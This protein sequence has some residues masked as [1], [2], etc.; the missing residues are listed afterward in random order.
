M[1]GIFFDLD[2]VICDNFLGKMNEI[3]R[4][5]KILNQLISL[6]TMIRVP[7]PGPTITTGARAEE[8]EIDPL[9]TQI[10]IEGRGESSLISKLAKKFEHKPNLFLLIDDMYC[11]TATLT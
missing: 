8:N 9:L 3:L 10:W 2:Y 7:V 1:N 11:T 5:L 6:L 4:T